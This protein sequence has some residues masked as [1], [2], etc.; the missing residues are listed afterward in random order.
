MSGLCCPAQSL[1]PHLF[2]FSSF[3]SKKTPI[4]HGIGGVKKKLTMPLSKTSD[5]TYITIMM[6]AIVFM[7]IIIAVVPVTNSVIVDSGT[8]VTWHRL[9]WFYGRWYQYDRIPDNEYNN[10]GGLY[11]FAD[12]FSIVI[13]I[14]F[15]IAILLPFI[16]V[17]F[18]GKN[19]WDSILFQRIFASLI[20]A[21]SIAG[22]I[23]TVFFGLFYAK[24]TADPNMQLFIA[25][26]VAAIYFVSLFFLSLKPIVVSNQKPKPVMTPPPPQEGELMD[27]E[28]KL[29]KKRKF[30]D[31]IDEIE[32]T[33][34]KNV[35]GYLV[36]FF[37]L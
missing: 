32:E 15:S 7:N 17:F 10:F 19:K 23:A 29:A 2:Y 3:L 25:F 8:G 6:V 1:T 22:I 28:K 27:E 11:D 21:G 13:P 31:H 20:T 5:K 35:A 34:T 18:I 36:P 37:T 33:A 9:T 12:G 24:Q 30:F 16:G 26:Y 4:I 14:L